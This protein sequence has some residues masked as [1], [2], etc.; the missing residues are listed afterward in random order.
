MMRFWAD[1]SCSLMFVYCTLLLDFVSSTIL[2]HF[3]RP[4]SFCGMPFTS[5]ILISL[6]T[7]SSH[8]PNC[9]LP[10]RLSSFGCHAVVFPIISFS[11]L[12]TWPYHLILIILFVVSVV[13]Q[14]FNFLF[15]HRCLNVLLIMIFSNVHNLSSF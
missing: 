11:L 10:L 8:L 15:S 3:A 7:C 9:D 5:I 6:T 2:L 12:Y 4:H 14:F 13:S 1:Q